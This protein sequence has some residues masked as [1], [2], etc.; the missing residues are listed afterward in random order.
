MAVALSA[1]FTG[2]ESTKKITDKDVQ[3][4]IQ[5]MERGKKTL[6]ISEFVDSLPAWR[7]GKTFWVVDE[8]VRLIFASSLDYDIDSLSL[9]DKQLTYQGYLTHR[10]VDNTELV[11]LKFSDGVHQLI[12]PTGRMMEDLSHNPLTVPFLVDGDMV[13]YYARQVVGKTVYIKTSA[14]QTLDGNKIEGRKFVPVTITAVKPGNRIYPLRV[15]FK[16]SDAVEAMLW[17]TTA[18][19]SIA[20]RD[21]GS[22]FSLTD[23]RLQYPEITAEVW[24]RIVDGKVAEGM[25]KE[26]CRLSMGTPKTVSQ[27]PDQTGLREYWYYDGGRYLF[28][29]DGL[30]K[31][32]R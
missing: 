2:V 16:T 19:S 21:F 17:M 32:F 25:T 20:G 18:K 26:E 10:Q 1:C 11:D 7:E 22:L 29:I 9:V 31:D 13:D 5:E 14:W 4:A 12:Y 15:E 28:F 23:V 6:A 27:L 3:R 8:Q 24:A 30:L